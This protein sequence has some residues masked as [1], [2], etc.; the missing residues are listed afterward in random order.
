MTGLTRKCQYALRALY[1][2]AREYG[3][4]PILIHYI[5]A[6]ANAPPGFLQGILFELKKAGVVESRR[7]TQ[8]GYY[9]RKSPD[10]V[11]V[12]SIIRIIDGPL[13]TLPCVGEREIHPC[14]DC[15]DPDACQTRLLMRGVHEAVTAILDHTTLLP[16]CK[17]PDAPEHALGARE[18]QVSVA[19]G[20]FQEA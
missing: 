12:G 18:S 14:A 16:I 10:Q 7:G 17:T 15:H 19:V 8:G 5:S 3:K 11:T 1:F 9:L 4:G 20:M 13:I 6:H 2:L